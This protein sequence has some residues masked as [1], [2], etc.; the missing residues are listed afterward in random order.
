MKV[1]ML[2][3][4]R[5]QIVKDQDEDS[6]VII[7]S[8]RSFLPEENRLHVNPIFRRKSDILSNIN[9]EQVV[10]TSE[11][12]MEEML[13]KSMQI[14]KYDTRSIEESFFVGIVMDRTSYEEICETLRNC[15]TEQILNK[16]ILNEEPL[17]LVEDIVCIQP[18]ILKC[19]NDLKND[20]LEYVVVEPVAY[21]HYNDFYNNMADLGYQV[22]ICDSQEGSNDRHAKPFD[23]L[24]DYVMNNSK[25]QK[26]EPHF[27]YATNIVVSANLISEKDKARTRK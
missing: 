16:D 1:E 5:A 4:L 20:S 9:T 14:R 24:V 15:S 2:R 19:S 12:R 6:V 11:K 25:C 8:K 23:L 26:E 3:R 22:D 27:D 13:T 10:A 17:S 18:G 21:V 7:T